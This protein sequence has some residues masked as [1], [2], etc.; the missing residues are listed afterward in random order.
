M[1]KL[2]Q[3]S[4]LPSSADAALLLIRVYFGLS[5]LWLHGKGKVEA[6]STMRTTFYDPLGVGNST[7]YFLALFGEV[8]FPILIILGLFTRLAALGSAFGLGV[9]FFLIHKGQLSGPTSG[10]LAFLYIGA[11][12]TLFIAGGGRFSVDARKGS[13]L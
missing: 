2:L 8:V 9:A 1:K 10:E 3:L 5:L 12:L 11:F 6:F 7:S 13:N 4:F